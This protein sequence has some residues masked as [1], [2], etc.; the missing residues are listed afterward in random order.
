MRIPL[1]INKSITDNLF[2]KSQ[3]IEEEPQ[4]QVEQEQQEYLAPMDISAHYGEVNR[5]VDNYSKLAQLAQNNAEM[6]MRV[7]DEKDISGFLHDPQKFTDDEWKMQVSETEKL[8]E[9]AAKL[10]PTL[11]QS[12]EESGEEL[13]AL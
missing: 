4:E 8:V 10:L 9:K 7:R 1:K 13:D 5:I 2:H 11:Y 6:W 3:L 12:E